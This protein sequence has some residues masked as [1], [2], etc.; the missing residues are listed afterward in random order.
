MERKPMDDDALYG[1]SGDNVVRI[2]ARGPAS[3]LPEV[4]FERRELDQL[5]RVYSFMVAGGDWRDYG[6]S[7]LR[8][9]AVFAVFRKASEMPLYRIEKNPKNARKQGMWSVITASGQIIKRGQ[10][11]GQVL[12]V[13]DKQLRLVQAD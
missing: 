11:L 12:K 10:D 5:L 6:I 9:R 7:H 1:G 4:R 2:E 8:D 13:F 3:S